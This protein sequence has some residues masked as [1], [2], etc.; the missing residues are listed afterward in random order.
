MCVLQASIPSIMLAPYPTA[1]EGWTNPALDKQ[2]E[3]AQAIVGS[4]RKLRTDYGLTKQRPAVYV[5]VSSSS[6]SSDSSG[7]VEVLQQLSGDIAC[8]ATCSE[9][10]LLQEGASAPA[11]C[12]V[13]IV[14]DA[15]TV[16]MQLKVSSFVQGWSAHNA[17]FTVLLHVKIGHNVSA[18]QQAG[19]TGCCG[20]RGQC[21]FCI[22]GTVHQHPEQALRPAK[23]ACSLSLHVCTGLS[24]SC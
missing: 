19:C 13:A 12:S 23:I 7:F 5:A 2:Y 3:Q 1:V 15:V 10:T 4:I 24:C 16:H 14:N 20:L 11:G 18:W 8:L 17:G 22:C 6:S 9:V 21:A